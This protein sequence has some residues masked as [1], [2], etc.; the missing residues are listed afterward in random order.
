MLTDDL[1]VTWVFIHNTRIF[2]LQPNHHML[3][4][5]AK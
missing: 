4:L 5:N 1:S 2:N 3:G